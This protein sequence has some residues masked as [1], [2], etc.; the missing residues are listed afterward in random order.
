ML[1]AVVAVTTVRQ[2]Q[3]VKLCVI[4]ERVLVRR[5]SMKATEFVVL[6]DKR[7]AAVSATM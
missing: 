2:D 5:V 6:A 1:I 7:T 4:P 3:M